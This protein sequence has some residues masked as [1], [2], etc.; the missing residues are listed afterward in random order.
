M[1]LST[2]AGTLLPILIIYLSLITCHYHS[3][4]LICNICVKAWVTSSLKGNLILRLVVLRLLLRLVVVLLHIEHNWWWLLYLTIRLSSVWTN[5]RWNLVRLLQHL[6]IHYTLTFP[7]F[8]WRWLL[9]LLRMRVLGTAQLILMLMGKLAT[10]NMLWCLLIRLYL[11]LMHLMGVRVL[12]LVIR[13]AYLF[14]ICLLVRINYVTILKAYFCLWL[15]LVQLIWQL[16]PF[17]LMPL[18]FK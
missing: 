2:W 9:M 3:S 18:H 12:N 7:F 8:F 1:R 16:F 4:A 14:E 11:H 5:A 17:Y 15:V 13:V 6:L 10:I